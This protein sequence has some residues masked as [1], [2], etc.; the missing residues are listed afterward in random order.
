MAVIAEIAA[1]KRSMATLVD[2]VTIDLKARRPMSDADRR[3]LK[4]EIEA[5]MQSLDELRTKLSG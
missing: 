5:L 3:M 2:G 1:L 4:R